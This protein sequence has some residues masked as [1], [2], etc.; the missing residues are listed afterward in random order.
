LSNGLEV[1][2]DGFPAHFTKTRDS[3]KLTGNSALS[4]PLSMKRYCSPMSF[5][6]DPLK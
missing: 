5:I 3:V 4:A 6:A 2:E 1:R